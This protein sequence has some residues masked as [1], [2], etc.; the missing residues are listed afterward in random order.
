MKKREFKSNLLFKKSVISNFNGTKLK[1][2]TIGIES[3]DRLHCE[4]EDCTQNCVTALYT[5][6]YQCPNTTC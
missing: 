1:G 4:T 2:G 5:N 3:A 6:C